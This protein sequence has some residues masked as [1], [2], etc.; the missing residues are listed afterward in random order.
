MNKKEDAKIEIKIW[1]K[2]YNILLDIGVEAEDI[3]FL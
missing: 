1:L 3:S 2:R